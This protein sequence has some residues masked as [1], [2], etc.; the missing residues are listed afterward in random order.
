MIYT[1][2]SILARNGGSYFLLGLVGVYVFY[3]SYELWV[4]AKR[5]ELDQHPIFGRECYKQN[6]NAGVTRPAGVGTAGGGG[7]G[8]EEE[9]GEPVPAQTDE[10]V[11]T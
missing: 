3:Q 10:A 11:M 9:A 6:N 1:L 7:N 4:A 2:I 8:D 5:D